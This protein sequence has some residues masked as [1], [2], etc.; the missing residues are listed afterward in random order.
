MPQAFKS[1]VEIIT[2]AM[3]FARHNCNRIAN[4]LVN[5]AVYPSEERPWTV[6]MAGSPGAG[7]TEVSKGFEAA[8]E[9]L[10]S[11]GFEGLGKVLRIDPDDFRACF[12]DYNGR[13]SSLFH[14]GVIKIVERVVDRAFAKNVSFILDGTLSSDAV[15][16][17]NIERSL[18]RGRDVTLLYVYQDPLRAWQFVQSREAVEG[19]NIPLQVFVAQ[20]FSC[21]RTVKAMKLLHGSSIR[22]DLLIQARD[23]QGQPTVL[24]DVTAAAIDAAIPDTYSEE[25]LLQRLSKGGG[26]DDE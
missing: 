1:D 10:P 17:R 24:E 5:L 25:Q 6:L 2:D 7:K 3:K 4:E 26:D 20:Y 21:R 19:R 8:L 16:K 12:P 15:A 18:R 22:V 14:S 13:N 9:E 11:E 23:G